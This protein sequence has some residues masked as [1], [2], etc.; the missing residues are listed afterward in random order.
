V[1]TRQGIVRGSAR[2]VTGVVG[3]AVAAAAVAV[4]L[5]VPLPSHTVA[6]PAVKVTPV[7]T[8]QA[9]VC[10][11]PIL[12]L[13][14]DSS[15]AAAAS[16][17]GTPAT[18][19]GARTDAG[20]ATGTGTGTGAE[21]ANPQRKALKTGGSSSHNGAPLLITVPVAPGATRPPLIVGSQSQRATQEDLS[22][23]AAAACDDASADS[24][25]VA[26]ATS[27]GQT[28]LVLLTNPGAA[29]ATVDLTVYG[30]SGPVSAPGG[31]GISVPAGAQ[32]I[33]PLA[34]LAPSVSAPVVHVQTHG[35]R[36]LATMQQSV[37]QGI[38]PGGVEMTAATGAPSTRQQIAGMMVRTLSTLKASQSSEGYGSN[39]PALRVLVPGS[40][41][42]QVS[43]GVVGETGTATG[44]AYTA[45]LKPGVVTEIPLDA[46]S[47]GNYTLDVTSDQPI[48]AAARTS[49]ASA[50]AKDF[51]W[52][53]ASSPLSDAFL[54]PI[55]AGPG[56]TLHLLNTATTDAALTITSRAGV[57][58]KVTV[59]A[60]AGTS[61][62]LPT[63]G[64]YAVAGAAGLVASVGYSGD[65]QLASFA[66]QPAAPLASAI[67]VYPR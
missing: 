36:V 28:S 20:A 12:A 10:P 33:V 35:G 5:W 43:V 44:D 57:A 60:G 11:G 21:Q 49:T 39:L 42:A 41:P 22:G 15:N 59:P 58:Q 45:T 55:S 67:T 47:D 56:A 29:L 3:I 63:A 18:V 38:E 19:A 9:R 65:G 54:A 61:V 7:P 23:L 2:A 30:E 16:A 26:G 64:V 62:A 6:P 50:T 34:G 37:V 51:A 40:K 24:W 66:L 1:S 31:T 27:L 17:F 8:D 53:T 52:F 14:A 13:A 32:K 4:A 25:L 46:L 48:V